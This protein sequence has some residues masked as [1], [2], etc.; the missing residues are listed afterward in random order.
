[1]ATRGVRVWRRTD[2]TLPPSFLIEHSR[3][4]T[5]LLFENNASLEISR[6]QFED[7]KQGYLKISDSYGLI[8][9]LRTKEE[10]Y[11]LTVKGVLSA[12]QLHNSDIYKI[13][14]TEF[15]PLRA[16]GL[17][18]NIDLRIPEL[19]KLIS[20]GM[21]YFSSS[22]DY[23]LT[24]CAQKRSENAE[25][26]ERFF[27]NR[28]LHFPLQRFGI[29]S[30]QWFLKCISGSVL[31][32]TVY[33]GAKTGKVALLSRLSCERVGTRFN[34]RGA[35]DM[36]HVANFVETEQLILFDNQESSF[37]QIR[38]SIP[39]FWDQPGL[40][41]GSHKVKLRAFEASAPAYKR[42][43]LSLEKNYKDIVVTQHKKTKLLD[44][45]PFIEFD[46]HARMKAS[47]ENINYLKK[48]LQR[49]VD[50]HGFFHCVDG[51]VLRTQSGVVRTNCLDC[52]D[53]TNSV[54][55]VLGIQSVGNQVTAMR[56][57]SANV[58]MQQRFEETLKDV[59]VRNGDQ[60]SI[61]YAGTGAL[62]GKSKASQYRNFYF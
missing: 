59:W 16:I 51:K 15:I 38:G 4:E 14:M 21:F 50:Q 58:N 61:I 33:V 3:N 55:T 11:L 62:E 36:G 24:L 40:Q 34:V 7:W 28:S 47:R 10:S 35:N 6:P 60:C 29:D 20:S 23:D 12:G 41:V 32:R 39:L 48:D 45:V 56:I 30:K 18:E 9:I 54:Q 25:S 44:T 53:R 5:C 31:V 42:H 2:V 19:Q 17:A 27:W 1:M 57:E 52:L 26:D 49:Y 8:G 22:P 13:T 43:F 37:V 46:Y